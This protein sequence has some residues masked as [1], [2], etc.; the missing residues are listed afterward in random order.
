[1]KQIFITII[2]TLLLACINTRSY[3]HG[4]GGDFIKEQNGYTIDIGYDP[5]TFYVGEAVNFDF[6]L[7][8]DTL[9]QEFSDVWVR[10][11]QDTKTVFATGVH[12]QDLGGTTL[13][14]E[15][16][17][18]GNYTLHVRYQKDGENIAEVEFPIIV[19]PFYFPNASNSPKPITFIM[20]VLFAFLIGTALG[21]IIGRTLKFLK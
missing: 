7:K 1:M 5:Q 4:T 3:A 21:I 16:E 15:F 12:S 17:K 13:L 14:Y 6:T 2:F 20:G 11:T 9:K 10:I 18:E 19:T 8:K